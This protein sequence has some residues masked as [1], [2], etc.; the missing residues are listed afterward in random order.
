[1]QATENECKNILEN[2]LH[3]SLAELE[4]QHNARID[5]LQ[6]LLDKSEMRIT[7]L[8]SLL[9]Q[10]E[11][12]IKQNH[13]Q[14]LNG[15]SETAELQCKLNKSQEEKKVLQA[16]ISQLESAAK[17]DADSDVCLLPMLA[18]ASVCCL[19]IVYVADGEGF[20]ITIAPHALLNSA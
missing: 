1:M 9:H 3:Q 14:L 10:S 7:D 11:C 4:H 5:G 16:Q 2:E 15:N 20:N 18:A 8:A 19:L 6:T 17:A 13:R 12:V